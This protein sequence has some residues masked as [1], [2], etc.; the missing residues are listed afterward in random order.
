M[1]YQR[2]WRLLRGRGAPGCPE[3]LINS[4]FSTTPRRAPV[5]REK[6]RT[7]LVERQFRRHPAQARER[8]RQPSISADSRGSSASRSSTMSL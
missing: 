7:H 4:A 8:A 1:G 2:H 6:H 3:K 5:I